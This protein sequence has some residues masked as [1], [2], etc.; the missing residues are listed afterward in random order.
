MPKTCRVLW[1][2]KFWIFD[3][4]S[5]LFHMKL[6]MIHGHLNMKHLKMWFSYR[7]H[8]NPHTGNICYMQFST[9]IFCSLATGLC[10]V[11]MQYKFSQTQVLTCWLLHTSVCIIMFSVSLLTVGYSVIQAQTK[12]PLPLVGVIAVPNVLVIWEYLS[13]S[14]FQPAAMYHSVVQQM[15]INISG[16]PSTPWRQRQQGLQK[17]WSLSTKLHDVTFYKSILPYS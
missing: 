1:Q 4:C 11:S 9:Q 10:N 8:Q 13:N 16:K 12:I 2:N 3:A 5:W 15:G 7:T 17:S 14:R 6:I